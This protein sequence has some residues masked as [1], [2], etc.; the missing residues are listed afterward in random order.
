[1]RWVLWISFFLGVLLGI[2][3]ASPFIAL[4]RAKCVSLTMAEDKFFDG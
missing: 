4:Q 2:Y 1:M 3:F